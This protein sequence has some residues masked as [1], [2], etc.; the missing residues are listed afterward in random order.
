M[1]HNFAPLESN[2]PTVIALM[3]SVFTSHQF[4]LRLAQ[5]NQSLYIEA[6]SANRADPAPSR[7]VHSRLSR[8]LHDFPHLVRHRGSVASNDIFGDPC[9]CA[10]WQ[11]I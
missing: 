4:I 5:L 7:R 3:P 10:E 9:E 8:R 1:P 2:Y 6:L 11:R